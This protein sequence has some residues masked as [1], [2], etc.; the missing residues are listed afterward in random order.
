MGELTATLGLME[1]LRDAEPDP[2]L[3]GLFEQAYQR[4]LEIHYADTR[5][6]IKEAP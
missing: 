5:A 1:A 6:L 2:Q 3:R 4:L